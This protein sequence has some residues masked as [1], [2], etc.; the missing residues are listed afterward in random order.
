MLVAVHVLRL[1]RWAPD[2]S[3]TALVR[4][5]A[6][7]YTACIKS[8]ADAALQTTQRQGVLQIGPAGVQLHSAW[9]TCCYSKF[10]CPLCSGSCSETITVTQFLTSFILY[11]KM[12]S[13]H[14][15][16]W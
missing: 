8:T 11:T 1:M 9:D 14:V 5:R 4:A 13:A 12:Q 16:A 10:C 3:V 2:K 15:L 7:D 6:K